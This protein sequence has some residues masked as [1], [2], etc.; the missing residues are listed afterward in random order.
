MWAV[1]CPFPQVDMSFKFATFSFLAILSG[2][3]SLVTWGATAYS[4]I[5]FSSAFGNW[6]D[7]PILASSEELQLDLSVFIFHCSHLF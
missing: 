3:K 5:L 7:L 4:V 6:L 1:L 2:L